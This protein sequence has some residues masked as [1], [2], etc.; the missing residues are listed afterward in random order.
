MTRKKKINSENGEHNNHREMTDNEDNNSLN[1]NDLNNTGEDQMNKSLGEDLIPQSEEIVEESEKPADKELPKEITAEEKLADMQDRYLRLSADFDNYRKRTLK[2][3]MELTKSAGECILLNIIPVMDDFE[4]ALK[5]METTTDCV[6][7]KNGI[8]LIYSK[9]R[10][11][12]KQNNLKEIDSLNSPF[13][14]DLHEAISKIPV[15]EENKKGKVIEVIEKGYY[16]NNKVIRFAKV[17][18][19]E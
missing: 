17:I 5:L 2:E 14:V 1:D 19:G 15:Q 11:F 9:F 7:M 3:K 18:V 10:D 16:L 4:R 6:G 12:L 8:D 13:N